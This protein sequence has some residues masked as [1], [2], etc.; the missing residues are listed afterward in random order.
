MGALFNY[1]KFKAFDSN[2]NILVGGKLWT[3]Q[4]GTVSLKTTYHDKDLTQPHTNPII[5]DSNGEAV[6][7]F[8]TDGFYDIIL[9]DSNDV[10]IW[11]MDSVG[12]IGSVFTTGSVVA[13]E[14]A[15]F[16]DSSGN[17]IKGGLGE[18]VKVGIVELENGVTLSDDSG[19]DR[20]FVKIGDA[21]AA[22]ITVDD[23]T[24]NDITATGNI[25]VTGTADIDGI[26]TFGPHSVQLST[27][28]A[29]T[30]MI[31]NAGDTDYA[32]L[33]CKN[34]IIDNIGTDDFSLLYDG[35]A[36]ANI[37]TSGYIS[38]AMTRIAYGQYR[39]T[40]TDFN[41]LT[42]GVVSISAWGSVENGTA[43]ELA[44]AG[45]GD[46]YNF[47][48]ELIDEIAGSNRIYHSYSAVP[49]TVPMIKIYNITSTYIEFWTY[50]NVQTFS[51]I[52]GDAGGTWTNTAPFPWTNDPTA[53]DGRADVD[54]IS[55]H[56]KEI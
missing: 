27:E 1:P 53:V 17:L 18:T 25:D 26:T 16:A 19:G 47:N 29:S 2:G 13:N 36:A 31:R 15:V 45:G 12:G 32:Y 44:I 43:Q 14:I 20:L 37:A 48:G 33:H 4:T 46:P 10:E 21:G 9:M 40:F 28:N 22:D 55:I 24:C 35:R 42:D 7:Y 56:V 30:A 11:S 34:L 3:Y 50:F 8:Q 5:L 41:P 39:L 52:S 38:A 6:I 23:I 49:D 54:W 51:F